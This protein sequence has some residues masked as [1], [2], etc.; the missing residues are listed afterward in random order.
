MMSVLLL[1]TAST[2][3]VSNGYQ[4]VYGASNFPTSDLGTKKATNIKIKE[5]FEPS[6]IVDAVNVTLVLSDLES[7]SLRVGT[8]LVKWNQFPSPVGGCGGGFD[9]SEVSLIEIPGLGNGALQVICKSYVH[10]T[11]SDVFEFRISISDLP[12]Q[13]AP[14]VVH[15]LV[16]GANSY[17][18]Y[19]TIP[20]TGYDFI[21]AQ[22][23]V[24]P[25]LL[26]P[27][28]S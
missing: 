25:K 21:F 13:M 5:L 4:K 26:N 1:I 2:G 6:P 17:T 27:D 18:G 15:Y 14:A 10:T 19:T 8:S 9:T 7:G 23:T 28:Q 12:H 3:F 22:V 20:L 24:E 16:L 11:I